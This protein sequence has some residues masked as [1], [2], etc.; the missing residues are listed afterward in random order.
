M[1]AWRDLK[2][3]NIDEA[4]VLLA[5][6]S[7]D[8]NVSVEHGASEAPKRLRKLSYHLP[9][10]SK[11]GL[12]LQPIRLYDFGDIGDNFSKF[13]NVEKEAFDIISQNKF[14]VFLGGDHSC[15]IPLQKAF[16]N[17][18]SQ[19]KIPAIIHIDAH[20]DICDAYE[21]NRYSHACPNYRALDV[22]Y[23]MEDIKLLAIRGFE[24]QEID[25]FNQHPEIE[26]ITASEINEQGL[27]CIKHLQDKF[28]D[29]YA[30][31]LSFDIDSID[32]SFAPGTGTPEAFG[33]TS[34]MANQILT[35]LVENLPVV[36][37]DIMEVA[38]RLDI[39]N[40]TSWTALKLL[41]EVFASLVK[42]Q[43]I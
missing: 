22:G 26:V 42:K 38:P 2:I 18:Y 10:A 4:N 39:N 32:P 7:F 29:R 19:T 13:E 40:I 11:D 24:Q 14:T 35:F 8:K 27:E 34:S 5:S 16:Y 37:F 43:K 21:D 1:K 3:N 9:A 41:Y 36:A 31:Y 28:D 33:I 15:S 17:H 12:S 30:I 6:V 20:P 25:L 23:K